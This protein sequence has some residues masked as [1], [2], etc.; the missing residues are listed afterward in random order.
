MSLGPL[1]ATEIDA[2]AKVEMLGGQAVLVDF[3]GTW[4]GMGGGEGAAGYRLIGAL[5]CDTSGS[6]FLKMVGPD[7]VVGGEVESFKS[8]ARSLRRAQE[9]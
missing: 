2:L 6:A 5:L 4:T 7:A 9:H 3:A 1:G 8:L